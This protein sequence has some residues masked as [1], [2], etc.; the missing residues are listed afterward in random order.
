[1]A[2]LEHA[3]LATQDDADLTL[4]QAHPRI[5]PDLELNSNTSITVLTGFTLLAWNNADIQ[6]CCDYPEAGET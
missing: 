2:N 1:M 6:C 3:T 5:M 4:L